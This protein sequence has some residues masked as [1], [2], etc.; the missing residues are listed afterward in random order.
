MEQVEWLPEERE[1][2]EEDFLP[3]GPTGGGGLWGGWSGRGLLG[4]DRDLLGDRR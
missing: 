1:P 4:T 3:D 2:S